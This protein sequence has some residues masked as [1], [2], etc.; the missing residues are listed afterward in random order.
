[1]AGRIPTGQKE[2]I[3]GK[4]LETVKQ[5]KM[6]LKAAAVTM[7]VGYRQGIRLYAA[8]REAGDGGLVHGNRGRRSNNRLAEAVREKALRAYRERYGDF[9]P[10]FAAEK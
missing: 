1:M 2:L 4:M 3:R 7:G 5:G 9:G 8:Y 6:T 10:T